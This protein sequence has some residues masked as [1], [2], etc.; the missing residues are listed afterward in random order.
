ME[1][2]EKISYHENSMYHR[3]ANT[4][5]LLRENSL[6]SINQQ[7]YKQISTETQYWI[8]VLK[9]VVAVIKYLS[10]HGLPF[11]GD[12]EVFGE[13]YYGNFLGL[14]ELISEFDPFLKTHIELHGNKGRGH[15]SYLSKT[16]LNELI[17][18]IKRR[19]INYIE[20]ETEKVNIFHLFWTQLRICLRQIKWQ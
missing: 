17:I 19:V 20:N 2:F 14:L 1:K 13:K 8:E 12:N 18:L 11:R 7:I 9:R 16:I 10:S 3:E 15:P 6:N 5:W 4:T